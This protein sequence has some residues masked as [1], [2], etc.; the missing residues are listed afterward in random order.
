MEC[1]IVGLQGV[2]KTTLF[3]A[4]T[5][6]VVAV[7]PGSMKPNLGAASIPDSRLDRIEDF[8][9]T[10]KVVHANLQVVD[11]PGIPSS[12]GAAALGAVLAHIRNVD[13]LCHVVR[14]HAGEGLGS[15]KGR[16]DIE[17]M[18]TELILSD[19]VVIEGAIDKAS[20]SARAG[21][22]ESKRRLDVVERC[23]ALIDA[24]QPIRA[25]R[26]DENDRLVL[27]SYGFMSAKP[28]LYVANVAEDDLAGESDAAREVAEYAR[29]N[30]GQSVA[31]CATLESEV[32]ELDEA[33]RTE[34]LESLGLTE[35][36]LGALARAANDL[37]GLTTFYTVGEKQIRA[38]S[39]P[40]GATAPQGA[41]AIHSDFE[42]GFIRAECYHV[43]ELFELKSEKAIKVA[44]KMR[45]EGKQYTL[46]D[47]DVVHFLFNV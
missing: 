23:K 35:P 29:A 28:V 14:C 4:L 12:S 7:Q 40:K 20:R 3:Q 38:W 27:K 33:D 46:Q 5:A 41:G 43:E 45:S 16:G 9:T 11:I 21:D 19:L 36:A 8:I 2:G 26:W 32:S 42:R 22:A 17:G 13:A 1:G 37:L 39:I 25:G 6:H 30:D 47:G 44:G 15:P 10:Q 34:M 24:E 31:L 18:E